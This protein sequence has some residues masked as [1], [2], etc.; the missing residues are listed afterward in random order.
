MANE[1]HVH[2]VYVNAFGSRW[3]FGL[4]VTSLGVSTKLLYVE[5]S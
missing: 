3:W 4:V 2:K 1:M 5:P